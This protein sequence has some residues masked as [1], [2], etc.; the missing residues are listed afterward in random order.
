V[1]GNLSIM[2]AVRPPIP[3]GVSADGFGARARLNFQIC[4]AR[5]SSIGAARTTR[6]FHKTAALMELWAI[7]LQINGEQHL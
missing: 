5:S 4:R 3:P 6:A 7:C 2:I 1:A